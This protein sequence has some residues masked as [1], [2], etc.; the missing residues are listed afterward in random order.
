M[1]KLP[2]V[3]AFAGAVV[4][5]S[6]TT[7]PPSVGSQGIVGGPLTCNAPSGETALFD[8]TSGGPV[9]RLFL[10][11]EQVFFSSTTGLSSVPLS[12][13]SVTAIASAATGV[14][15][16]GSTLYYVGEHP[17]GVPDAQG[18][19]SSATGLYA[20]LSGGPIDGGTS[21]GGVSTLVQDDFS[22]GSV[23]TDNNSLFV[24][25]A[26]LGTVLKVTPPSTSPVSL[27]FGGSLSIRA[28]AVDATY[29]YAAVEDLTT[30]PGSGAIVRMPK[31]GGAT[32]RVLTLAGF[33]DA[34]VVDDKAL[35][36]ID[37]PPVGTFGN[38]R[39]V[40]ADLDGQ[41]EVALVDASNNDGSV[42]D[43]ALGPDYLY[44]LSEGLARVPK[45]GGPVAIIVSELTAPGLLQVSGA[46]VVW[47]DNFYR[48]LSSTALTPIE[49]LCVDGSSP[50]DA[51]R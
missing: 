43:I 21:D 31:S 46:D 40:R 2:L 34:L 42:G 32:E 35:Y 19:Q 22:V 6:S 25:G 3:V 4:A 30:Q 10:L 44:F 20:T 38:T 11:G 48:A 16:V 7:T 36:W 41:N 50:A 26:G 8:D 28:L 1:S 33:P 17:V 23:V 9:G 39:V 37:Q 45:A 12:G 29:L 15:M 5:C 49:A 18:K 27:T 24:A 13:G 51:G 47:V 14:A